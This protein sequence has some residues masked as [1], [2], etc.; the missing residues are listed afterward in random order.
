M[1]FNRTGYWLLAL[2]G[3]GGL[4]FLAAGFLIDD[5]TG[6]FKIIGLT[7]VLVVVALVVY[8]HHQTRRAKHERWLF[9][10]GL[11]G[12]AKLVSAGSN[13]EVN[14][15]PVVRMELDV[16]VPGQEPRRITQNVLMSR[17]AAYR[18]K[19]GVVLPV[20]ANPDPRR[21]EDL[22]VRW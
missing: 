16:D 2:F 7:W 5:P 1:K 6:A 18:M 15:N 13:V 3:V 20:H 17:F 19:P 4:I 10:N 9:E 21:P 14:G 22:L 8:A 11:R 12:S